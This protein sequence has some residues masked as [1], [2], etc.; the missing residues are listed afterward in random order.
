M[1][2]SAVQKIIYSPSSIS[3]QLLSC[4]F[5]DKNKKKGVW[6]LLFNKHPT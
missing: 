4:F 5:I 1:M 2:I 6:G 3:F